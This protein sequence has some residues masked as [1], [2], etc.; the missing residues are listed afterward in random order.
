MGWMWELLF[1]HVVLL[2]HIY[3]HTHTHTWM[4]TRSG[5][6]IGNPVFYKLLVYVYNF[7]SHHQTSWCCVASVYSHTIVSLHAT[8]VTLG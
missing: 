7:I 1:F 6:A 3:V 8:P 2:A 5:N 4:L